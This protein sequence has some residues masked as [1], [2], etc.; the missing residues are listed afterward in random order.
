M[1]SLTR[2][3]TVGWPFSSSHLDIPK[4]DNG[5]FQNGRW[6][7]SFKNFSRRGV[8]KLKLL[9]VIYRTRTQTVQ[10]LSKDSGLLNGERMCSLLELLLNKIL[11]QANLF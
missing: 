5:Q 4:N 10:G 3:Y 6:I 11:V 2:L 1:C 7:L 9:S 8:N